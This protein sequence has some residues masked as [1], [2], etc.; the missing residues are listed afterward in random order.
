MGRLKPRNR[1]RAFLSTRMKL[2]IGASVFALVFV[3]TFIVIKFSEVDE[4]YAYVE[5]DYRTSG[6]GSWDDESIWEQYDGDKWN[7]VLTIPNQKNAVIIIDSG[8]VVLMEEEIIVSKFIIKNGAVVE[9]LSNSIKIEKNRGEGY[10]RCDGNID[11]GECIIE[12]NADFISN[13]D[14]EL[15]FGSPYGFS[16]SGSKGNIQLKG[17]YTLSENTT[18]IYNGSLPQESGDGLPDAITGLVIDNVEGVTLSEDVIVAGKLELLKGVLYTGNQKISLGV[19]PDQPFELVALSGAICGEF[20]YM[21]SLA[22]NKTYRIPV[23]DGRDRL[24]VELTVENKNLKDGYL[25]VKYY[26]GSVTAADRSPFDAREYVIAISERGFFTSMVNQGLKDAIYL[27]KGVTLGVDG[28]VST[29]WSLMNYRNVSKSEKDLSKD[30]A[31]PS[32][33]LIS[34]IIYGPNPFS[35][36]ISMR[37][38]SEQSCM[39]MIDIVSADG[40]SVHQSNLDVDKGFNNWEYNVG[41]TLAPGNYFIRISSS[42]EIHSFLMTKENLPG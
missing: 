18:F 6:S 21:S 37:F 35:N 36:K 1:Q 26:K 16:K 41:Q 42:N 14:A 11:F 4:T 5:G 29:I 40:K 38:S 19:K 12:G 10:L 24:N 7:P 32:S 17:K 15:R 22:K 39:V 34:N 27:F 28:D 20:R 25:I 23:S 13:G 9:L 3:A 2:I 31:I 8:H 30:S 33:E